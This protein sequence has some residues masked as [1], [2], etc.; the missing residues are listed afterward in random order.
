MGWD[1]YAEPVKFRRFGLEEEPHP[2]WKKAVDRARELNTQD[3]IVDGLLSRGGLDCSA[4]KDE[5]EQATG[6]NCYSDWNPEIVRIANETAD[7]DSPVDPDQVWARASARAFLERCA[8]L[9]LSIHFS[10]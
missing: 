4:C 1:A 9:G 3:Q 6:L 7:W 2:D 10:Y 5:L 8:E